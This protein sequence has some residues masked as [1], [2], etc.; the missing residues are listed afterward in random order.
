LRRILQRRGRL[1]H[2]PGLMPGFGPAAAFDEFL[3]DRLRQ[4]EL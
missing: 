4:L 3:L 2:A 1:E